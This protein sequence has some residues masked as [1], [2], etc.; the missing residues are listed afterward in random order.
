[1]AECLAMTMLC[2]QYPLAILVLPEALLQSGWTT[3]Y[4]WGQ[5]TLLTGAV[6]LDGEITI[7][8]I[9]K[10]LESYACPKTVGIA[11]S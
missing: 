9:A 4:A 2:V 5:R 7:V 10:M 11:S 8:V 1:M 3:Y 6:F